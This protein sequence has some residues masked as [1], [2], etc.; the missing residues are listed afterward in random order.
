MRKWEGG[1]A[2]KFCMADDSVRA[3]A[4]DFLLIISYNRAVRGSIKIS[5]CF[6]QVFLFRKS[7]QFSVKYAI[8][9]RTNGREISFGILFIYTQSDRMREN[10]Y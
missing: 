2:E 4:L 1:S 9:N 8:I 5:G 10:R 6:F 7:L 3:R